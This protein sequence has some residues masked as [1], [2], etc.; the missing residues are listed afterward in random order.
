MVSA[1]M[2]SSLSCGVPTASASLRDARRVPGHDGWPRHVS[3]KNAMKIP[4]R[5]LL[6][7]AADAVALR[8]RTSGAHDAA[9][10]AGLQKAVVLVTIKNDTL[11][12]TVC[13]KELVPE[14]RKSRIVQG[15]KAD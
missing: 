12:G 1:A 14:H 13:R 9:P 7:L 4:C 2:A 3:E 8:A 10:K 11:R 15:Y 5:R 6:N